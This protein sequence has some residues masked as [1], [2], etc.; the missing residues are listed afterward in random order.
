MV[1]QHYKIQ[2]FDGGQPARDHAL[3]RFWGLFVLGVWGCAGAGFPDV[4]DPNEVS[5]SLGAPSIDRVRDAGNVHLPG[6]GAWKGESDGVAGPGELVVIEGDNFGR[7]PTVSIGGRA[8]TIVARTSGGGIVARVPTGVPVGKVSVSV[9]Q[10]KGRAQKD[11]LI[12]RLAVVVHDGKLHFLEVGKDGLRLMGAP[13]TVPGAGTL[14]LAADGG[15]AYLLA[16]DKLVA[17][18]LGAAG[19][20]REPRDRARP[21]RARAHRRRG[22][23]AGGGDRRRQDDAV[24]DA[25]IEP[26]RALRGHRAAEGGQER[27][28]L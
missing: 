16:N 17:V 23:A 5:S 7:L 19:A 28:H 26:P 20:R 27:A 21:P 24:L 25:A 11:L 2:P 9:S 4:I 10:P 3:M 12:R 22:C 13:L 1:T 8:T 15:A 18:D 14:R 6:V